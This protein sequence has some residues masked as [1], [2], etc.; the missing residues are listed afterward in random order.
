MTSYTHSGVPIGWCGVGARPNAHTHA[1][2]VVR[3]LETRET[4]A[5]VG[6]HGVL[7]G[8]VPTRLAVTLVNVWETGRGRGE[9]DVTSQPFI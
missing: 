8:A 7:A 4:Q 6:A 3:E 1:V 5:V 9:Q 2:V